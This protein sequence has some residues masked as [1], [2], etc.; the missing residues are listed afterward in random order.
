M[1]TQT[2]LRGEKLSQCRHFLDKRG[3][4]FA[5]LCGRRF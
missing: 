3:H 4:F 2:T 5:I 1:S